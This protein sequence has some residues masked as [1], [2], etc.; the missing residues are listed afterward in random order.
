MQAAGHKIALAVLTEEKDRVA[1]RFAEATRGCGPGSFLWPLRRRSAFGVLLSSFVKRRLYFIERYSDPGFQQKLAG[2]IES[3]R[4]D[5]VHFDLILMTQ[6]RRVAPVHVGTVASINDSYTLT[7]DSALAAG[8]HSGLQALYR[9]YQRRQSRAY[10]RHEYAR[11]DVVHVVSQVDARFLTALNAKIHVVVIPNGV[12]ESLVECVSTNRDGR[13]VLFV[14]KLA[15]DNL[16][17]L[18][19]FL[20]R[21]WLLISAA[22]KEATFDIVGGLDQ[23]AELLRKTWSSDPSVRFSGYVE[24][25]SAAYGN[26]TVAVVPVNKTAGLVNKAIEAMAAGVVPVGF[27]SAFN[28]IEGAVDGIHFV[29][30]SS[31]EEIGERVIRLLKDSEWRNR[32]SVA[33]RELAKARYAWQSRGRD[34]EAAYATAAQR[35]KSSKAAK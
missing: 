31:Y 3:F 27:A 32:I 28:G 25:L 23:E 26:S 6:Y 7:L 10:E 2:L 15:R 35:H 30:A 12:D 29:S 8:E 14:G 16:Y 34:F 5:V 13:A 4:P 19:M 20:E 9:R 24:K 22:I 1:E 21:G 33:G 17:H 11:F 18:R